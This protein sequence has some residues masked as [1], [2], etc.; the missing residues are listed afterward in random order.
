MESDQ[1]IIGNYFLSGE[2]GK[3]NFGVVY[4]AMEIQ[5]KNFYAA[6]IIT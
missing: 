2:I 6:K 5:T 1:K 4:E 3:G